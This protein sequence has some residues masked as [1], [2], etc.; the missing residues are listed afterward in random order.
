MTDP[1]SLVA[2]AIG[3]Q[4]DDADREY[5]LRGAEYVPDGI[6]RI[7]RGQLHNA[8]DE[9]GGVSKRRLPGAVHE[10]RKAFKR[11]RATVRLSRDAVGDKTYERENAAYRKAGRH[12]SASRDAD[13]LLQTLDE[14]CGRFADE[15]P[16]RVT[17]RLRAG[18]RTHRERALKAL[19]DDDRAIAAVLSDLDNA[20]VRTPAWTFQD[21]GFDALAPGLKRIYRRGR[22]RMRAACKDP[23]PE[24]L[25]EWRKRVKDLWYAT[26]MVRPAEPERL[27]KLSKR[28]HKLADLLGDAHD[29][30]VLRD[31]ADQHPECF[32]DNAALAALVAVIDRRSRVLRD[33][34]LKRGKQVYARSPKRFVVRIARGWQQHAAPARPPVAG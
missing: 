2:R 16:A 32:D 3:S 6:R 14:L 26:Q 8:R 15:L 5:R 34:A 20:L 31:Y 24:N 17:D 22:K 23:S 25:H 27:R 9:L 29:L 11:L 28:A 12:L 33:R 10:A 4:P 18:L 30:H 7:A 1:I 21:D 13:V 19:R